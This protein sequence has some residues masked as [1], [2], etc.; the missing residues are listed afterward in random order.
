MSLRRALLIDLAV[1]AVGVAPLGACTLDFDR[2]DPAA[3]DGAASEPDAPVEPS[4]DAAALPPAD[5][6]AEAAPALEASAESSAADHESGACSVPPACVQQA[7]S[8]GAA[9]GQGYQACVQD[10]DAQTCIDACRTP[11]Q[12]CLG[13]CITVC[14]SCTADGGCSSSSACLNASQP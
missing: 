14:L 12:S 5:A 7:T 13:K 4:M 2:Y 11:E 10:C 9:C 1:A 8:C 6:T 3:G